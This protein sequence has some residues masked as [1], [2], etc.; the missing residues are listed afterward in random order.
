MTY[1]WTTQPKTSFK[2]INITG[3][4]SRMEIPDNF[5]EV[6]FVNGAKGEGARSGRKG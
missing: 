1:N 2:N 4:L 6:K 5:G 3:M